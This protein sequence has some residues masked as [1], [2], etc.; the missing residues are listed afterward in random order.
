MERL[1]AVKKI[2]PSGVEY[3]MARDIAPILG[4]EG[5]RNF[6]G[7]IERAKD[8][9]KKSGIEPSLQLVATNNRVGRNGNTQRADYYLT[10]GAC[11]LVA[12]NGDPSKPEVAAAQAYFAIQTRKME[13]QDAISDDQKRLELRDK[14]AGSMKKVSGVAQAAGVA[15]NHQ[16]IFHE[17]RYIGLYDARSAEV[18]A[19]KG[20]KPGDNLFDRAGP[21][22]L[23]AH[24]FQMNLAADIISKENIRGER[25]AIDKNLEVAKRVRR[26]IKDSGGTMPEA[27]PLAEHIADV[28]KR[29]TGRRTKSLP[30]PAIKP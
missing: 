17:Q 2:A 1:E 22:E 12:M 13:A 3:W 14:V 24:D 9:M 21:L 20:L 8:A 19:R 27:L 23:S 6:E 11:Y 26:T 10:R 7:V 5:W 28:R 29:V 18:K 30:K 15:S 25:A 16:G 4:Y